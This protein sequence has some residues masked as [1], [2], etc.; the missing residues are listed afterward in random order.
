[1][2]KDQAYREK[3]LSRRQLLKALIAAGGALTVSTVL[4]GQW[5]QPVVE[6][7]VLPA[8]AQGSVPTPCMV[9][10]TPSSTPTPR[11]TVAPTP[12]ATPG[13][14]RPTSPGGASAPP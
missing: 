12:S 3:V 8:H 2:R 1:M 5:S 4:P 9:P 7:G 6:V 13:G 10:P 14:P 11:P